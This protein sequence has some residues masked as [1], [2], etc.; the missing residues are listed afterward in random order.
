MQNIRRRCK[1]DT[2]KAEVHMIYVLNF[3]RDVARIFR[4]EVEDRLSNMHYYAAQHLDAYPAGFLDKLRNDFIDNLS[5]DYK[6]AVL[7]TVIRRTSIR[8]GVRGW[9]DRKFKALVRGM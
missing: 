7:K 9:V 3:D 8:R 2:D 5:N 1:Y 4:E 6:V